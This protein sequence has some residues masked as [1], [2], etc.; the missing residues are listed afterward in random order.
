MDSE[1]HLG[2]I[3]IPSFGLS[4]LQIK[5]DRVRLNYKGRCAKEP[6]P[7]PLPLHV[8]FL[9]HLPGFLLHWEI[10][11]NSSQESLNWLCTRGKRERERLSSLSFGDFE[12]KGLGWGGSAFFFKEQNHGDFFFFCKSE[13]LLNLIFCWLDWAGCNLRQ[14]VGRCLQLPLNS[15]MAAGTRFW[16]W[17]CWESSHKDIF[18]HGSPS[19]SA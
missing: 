17:C 13:M 11:K 15:K 12:I 1:Q 18:P 7:L 3:S 19:T 6:L 2:V 14:N 16:Q 5:M 10:R 9:P 8:P 4:Y